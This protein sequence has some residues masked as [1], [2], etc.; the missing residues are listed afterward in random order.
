[1]SRLRRRT[2]HLIYAWLFG[3][4]MVGIL[5]T[6]YVVSQSKQMK[7]EK[8]KII[9]HFEAQLKQVEEAR[10]QD[11]VSGF[12]VAREVPAGTRLSASDLIEV[13]MPSKA[14]PANQLR[15][16]EEIVGKSV[17][18]SLSAKTLLTD[19]L[20][21]K[22]GPTPD[23]LRWREMAFVQLPTQ[24]HKHDVIDIRIQFPT[25]QDY[26]LLSKKKIE[27]LDQGTMTLTL[28]ELEILTLSSAVVDAYMNK[29]TIYALVYVEPHLQEKAI[30]TYPVNEAVLVLIQKDPNIVPRAEYALSKASRELLE[31]GLSSLSPQ[32]TSEY[33]SQQAKIAA[34]TVETAD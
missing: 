31:A 6:L 5:L 20:L 1:M 23:D 9:A 30:P 22:D 26:I 17:K 14:V 7:E 4:S 24:L 19:S 28:D 34:E 16:R 29:A 3:A 12:V 27:R 33:V 18:V 32:Q 8:E 2:R 13:D 10:V 21:Y 25:G 11:T 15:S